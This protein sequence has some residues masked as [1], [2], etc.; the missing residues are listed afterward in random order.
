MGIVYP[1][2]VREHRHDFFFRQLQQVSS[3]QTQFRKG[4]RTV[5]EIDLLHQQAQLLR[6]ELLQ[7]LLE[8]VGGKS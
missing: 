2:G 6:G 3:L 1:T 4:S 7:G 5:V 8:R